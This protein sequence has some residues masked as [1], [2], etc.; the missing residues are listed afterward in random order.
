M[1]G[2]RKLDR[3]EFLALTGTAGTSL[4]VLRRFFIGLHQS[5]FRYV[6]ELLYND[7]IPFGYAIKNQRSFVDFNHFYFCFGKAPLSHQKDFVG[8]KYRV[9]GDLHG[10]FNGSC[11]K[12]CRQIFSGQEVLF[13]FGIDAYKNGLTLGAFV[14]KLT[15]PD[16]CPIPA[17]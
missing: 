14:N 1:T 4:H 10:I 8:I 2:F 3:R 6:D 11:R 9:P 5:T 15:F 16:D 17:Q 12:D 13:S 7:G